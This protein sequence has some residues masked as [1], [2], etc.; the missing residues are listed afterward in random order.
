VA[1]CHGWYDYWGQPVEVHLR[2][3]L[4]GRALFDGATIVPEQRRYP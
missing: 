2:E 4:A 3:P 1:A